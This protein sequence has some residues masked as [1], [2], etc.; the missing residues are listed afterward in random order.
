MKLAV[1][2]LLLCA[3]VGLLI[4]LVDFFV[5]G[6]AVFLPGQRVA[7]LVLGGCGVAVGVAALGGFGAAGTTVNPV[8]PDK[9]SALVTGGIYR[10]SRNPMYLSMALGLFAWTL[11][12]GNPLALPL[13]AFFV[14]YLTE[15]QIKPEEAALRAKFG[16]EF[17]AF[18]HRTRRW[19]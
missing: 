8:S 5:A 3:V 2:P 13:P 18:R 15:F 1:P 9:V 7:A 6:F 14:W 12:L 19:I 11:W 10:L 17:E 4:W 16:D